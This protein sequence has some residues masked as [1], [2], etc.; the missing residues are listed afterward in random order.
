MIVQV[1]TS[2]LS[3]EILWGHDLAPLLTYQKDNGRYKVDF[4]QF[5]NV[6]AVDTPEMSAKDMAAAAAAAAEADDGDKDDNGDDGISHQPAHE[7]ETSSKPV[8]DVKCD[9]QW[10]NNRNF[11]HILQAWLTASICGSFIA[12]FIWVPYNY[13]FF[14]F[15]KSEIAVL[16]IIWHFVICRNV[17]V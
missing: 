15:C 10:S 12:T 8:T 17:I 14:V 16:R 7:T 9:R 13:F 6:V 11:C 5:D 1:R 3:S 4:S 2:Y